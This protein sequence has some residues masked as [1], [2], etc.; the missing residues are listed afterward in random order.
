[1]TTTSNRE[2]VQRPSPHAHFPYLVFNEEKEFAKVRNYNY[3]VERR[4][5]TERN[6]GRLLGNFR[7]NSGN[8]HATLLRHQVQKYSQP[9]P[10]TAQKL[11]I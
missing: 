11:K 6:I 2:R 10:D 9:G 4:D 3:S 1:L 8:S 5:T 7:L